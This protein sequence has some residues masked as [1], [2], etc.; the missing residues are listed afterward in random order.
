MDGQSEVI[1]TNIEATR[2]ELTHKLEMLEHQIMD[3]IHGTTSAAAET[4][5]SVKDVAH[6]AVV[7]V[8][9]TVQGTIAAVKNARDLPMQVD[10]HPWLLLGA[11]VGVGYLTGAWLASANEA[12]GA[13][14]EG[15]KA[16]PNGAAH[17]NRSAEPTPT[18]SG[19][20]AE[21]GWLMTILGAQF[22]RL[23]KV[24][25]GTTLA[26]VR[27]LIAKN[28]AGDLGNRLTEMVD[29]INARMAAEPIRAAP[30]DGRARHRKNVGQAP[31]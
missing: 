11:S 3:T 6:D 20:A 22:D 4:M 19:G 15:A 10:H 29:T 18:R 24:S 2:T 7:S 1:R 28:L 21:P 8:K 26:I 31:A 13:R 17:T 14:Y 30:Q 12:D 23:K 5:G 27:D 25:L 9:D 16:G